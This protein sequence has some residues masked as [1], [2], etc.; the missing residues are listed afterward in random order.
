ML[1]RDM[2]AL[3]SADMSLLDR[4]ARLRAGN[5]RRVARRTVDLHHPD[6]LWWPELG[7]RKRDAF[8][9]YDAVAPVVLPHLRDRP[10]TLKQHFNGPRSPFRWLK[11][12]PPEAP[13]WIPATPQPA[14]S[15]GG[16]L[17]RY[18]L[19]NDRPTLLWLVDYG[20]VDLHVWTS[21]ADRPERPD[22]VL[23]DLDP[24]ASGGAFA[25]VEEAALVVRDA[26]DT[27]G[28]HGYPMT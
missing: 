18:V 22:F 3:R 1:P 27:L 10:F 2:S 5:I 14:K 26:L 20:C 28:L 9:Y 6:Q 7:L 17:V 8:A 16:A 21:R 25:A 23:L 11:D 15:R 19:V 24:D 13:E 12:K 4:S